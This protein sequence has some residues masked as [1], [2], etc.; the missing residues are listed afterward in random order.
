MLEF[1]LLAL[2]LLEEPGKFVR[3]SKGGAP[4]VSASLSD[5]LVL[6][7]EVTSADTVVVWKKGH[8]KVEQDQRTA[9]ISEGTQR[10]LVIR[11]AKQSDEGL[12]SCESA[13]DKMTFQVK[14]KG[15]RNG[16]HGSVGDHGSQVSLVVLKEGPGVLHK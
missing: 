1:S 14:I 15:E 2:G 16:T 12:Y 6:T 9:L 11:H 10:R 13:T 3:K 4:G 5:D 7:C 8:V